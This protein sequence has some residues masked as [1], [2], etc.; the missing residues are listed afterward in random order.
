LSGGTA[1]HIHLP[2]VAEVTSSNKKLFPDICDGGVFQEVLI[3][4]SY[5]ECLG[6]IKHNITEA[7]QFSKHV[8]F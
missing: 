1:C 4:G 2:V 6:F 8:F 7:I 3:F 5:P